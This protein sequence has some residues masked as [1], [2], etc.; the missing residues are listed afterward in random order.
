VRLAEIQIMPDNTSWTT[1]LIATHRRDTYS[2]T[3][4]LGFALFTATKR[5]RT[6]WRFQLTAEVAATLN[7]EKALLRLLA[8]ALPHPRFII[9]HRLESEVFAPLAYAADRMPPPLNAFLR[10]RIARFQSGIMVD[11]AP[12]TRYA[13]LPFAETPPTRQPMT[14]GVLDGNVVDPAGVKAELEQRVLEDW[15]SFLQLPRAA[16]CGT[17]KIATMTWAVSRG[18]GW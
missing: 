14:I 12:P 4:V 11:L 17:A 10:Y 9:G 1:I 2:T 16:A 15:A 6:D 13:P 7:D 5:T 18:C 3:H 8:D